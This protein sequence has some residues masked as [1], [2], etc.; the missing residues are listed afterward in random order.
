MA[1]SGPPLEGL[2]AGFLPFD[3]D[4]AES[5]FNDEDQVGTLAASLASFSVASRYA[6]ERLNEDQRRGF[7]RQAA[8]LSEGQVQ[9][10][11]VEAALRSV[12]GDRDAMAATDPSTMSGVHILGLI[13]LSSEYLTAEE[14]RALRPAATEYAKTLRPTLAALPR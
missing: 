8:A 1:E 13:L 4:A 6:L 14:C 7:C 9:A 10:W 11:M 12:E 3:V 5:A 2:V